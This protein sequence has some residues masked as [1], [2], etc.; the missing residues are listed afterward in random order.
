[1]MQQKDRLV[2]NSFGNGFADGRCSSCTMSP[3]I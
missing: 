1:M 3:V 2:G